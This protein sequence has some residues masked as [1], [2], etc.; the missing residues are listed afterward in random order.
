MPAYEHLNSFQSGRYI[1]V[2]RGFS[3][4]HHD[5][6]DTEALGVHWVTD[7]HA[8]WADR[9]ATDRMGELHDGESYP[10]YE[11]GTAITGLVHKRHIMDPESDE[12]EQWANAGDGAVEYENETPL[13]PG[14]PV[15][16]VQATDFNA[17][18]DDTDHVFNPR[19]RGR[20]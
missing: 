16:L 2:H 20:V 10:E 11:K 12:H 14:T 19:R 15:H 6:V 5:E 13:R 3:G 7:T 4:M 8:R 1:R 17:Y 18:G 9:F